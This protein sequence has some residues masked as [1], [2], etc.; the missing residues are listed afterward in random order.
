MDGTDA[1]AD[2]METELLAI[3]KD[4]DRLFGP[5]LS[6]P[7]IRAALDRLLPRADEGG[8]SRVTLLPDVRLMG[9]PLELL[10]AFRTRGARPVAR[11]FSIHVLA[12]RRLEYVRDYST[13]PLNPTTSH[14]HNFATALIACVL[15]PIISPY[16]T[17]SSPPRS[18][19]FECGT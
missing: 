7:P 12:H 2:T 19:I 1:G 4:M 11:D 13:P 10:S 6:S 9:L 18:Q 14:E 15:P 16:L 17:P 8:A 3:V 5:A